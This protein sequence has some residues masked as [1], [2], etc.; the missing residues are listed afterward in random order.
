MPSFSATYVAGILAGTLILLLV[1][2]LRAEL[3]A[4]LVLVALEIPGI[5]TREE[6]LSGFSSSA[7]ITIIGLFVLSSALERTGVADYMA[8]VLVQLGGRSEQRLIASLMALAALLSL[9]MNNIAAGA[10][11]LPATVTAG[12]R[13]RLA[14]SRLL[15]PL[16]FGASLGGMATIFTTAN[17]VVSSSLSQSGFAPLGFL[18]FLP[19][20]GLVALLGIAYMVFIGR[21][22]LPSA[23]PF[24]DQMSGI[25]L[26]EVYQLHERL[27]E[28][29]VTAESALVGRS[30]AEAQVGLSLGVTIV[31]IFREQSSLLTPGSEDR[32]RAGDVLLVTGGAEQVQRLPGVMV[33]RQTR[34]SGYFND[35]LVQVAEVVV[36]PRANILGQ[37]LKQIEF[38]RRY[39]VTV[40]AIWQEGRAHQTD[41]GDL[42]LHAGDALLVVGPAERLA[43]LQQNPA[44]I[45]VTPVA[46]SNVVRDP[47]KGVVAVGITTLVLGL[48]IGNWVATSIALLLGVVLLVL[49]HCLTMDEAIQAIEWKTVFVIA[50]LLPLSIAMQKT[51]LAALLGSTLVEL[52]GAYGFAA[53]VGAVFTVT[54][55]LT[56]VIGGQVTALVMAPIAIAAAAGLDISPRGIGI[57]VALACS[58]AFL[59]PLAHPVNL[60][61][62][63]PGGYTFRD[64]GRV[65][66]G[67]T[68]LC[69]VVVVV[70]RGLLPGG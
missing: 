69:F 51:G 39:G 44:L 55:L 20:G 14:A 61:M 65:G 43:Q 34:V 21:H 35:P 15:M 60:L 47:A 48:S 56:Q 62:M 4:L 19:L 11:L 8:R 13:V 45:V 2:R 5:L 3:V 6:A 17:I 18:D 30:L 38:R 64:F 63:G 7:V 9:V 53:L 40:V 67:L 24:A 23:D 49:T 36:A 41:V 10:V 58:V 31:A 28:V 1:V 57:V 27:W 16:A 22:L 59:T 25:V 52:V 50:G 29:Q 32:L 33:G 68:V 42:P 70:G 12:R 46:A 54:L 66:I 37:T 26:P